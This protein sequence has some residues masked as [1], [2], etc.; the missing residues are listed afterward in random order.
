VIRGWAGSL[1]IDANN[2][3]LVFTPIREKGAKPPQRI[4]IEHGESNLELWKNL[5][6]CARD[7]RKDTWSP[8]ELAFRTQTILHMAMHSYRR[9]VTAKFDPKR[10]QIV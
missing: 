4:P 5:I 3:D 8:A 10:R 2:K 6:A 9:G 7:G 1:T